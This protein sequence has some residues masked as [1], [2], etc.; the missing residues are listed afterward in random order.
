MGQDGQGQGAF[1]LRRRR[2]GL[3][4]VHQ[5]IDDD[6]LQLDPVAFDVG[7]VGCDLLAIEDAVVS[8]LALQKAAGV[9]R[10]DAKR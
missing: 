4:A 6:L 9:P 10:R 7:Q 2:H 3:D 8:Q 5:K 1:A